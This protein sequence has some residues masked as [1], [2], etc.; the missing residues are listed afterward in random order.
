MG[1]KKIIILVLL[2]FVVIG[3][4]IGVARKFSGQP[5]FPNFFGQWSGANK[6]NT[7]SLPQLSEQE[8][9]AQVSR[10]HWIDATNQQLAVDRDLDGLT[11]VEEEK[12]GTDP[13][14]EDTDGDGLKDF[15]EVKIYHTNP[16][17][18]DTDGDGVSDGLE[19]YQSDN[20]LGPGKIDWSKIHIIASGVAVPAPSTTPKK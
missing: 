20:P 9:A 18:A 4:G 17:K 2:A 16:L 14:Q 19:V 12:L 6:N 1:V 13:A 7:A 8:K 10:Q 5:F 15:Q 3:T 11:D